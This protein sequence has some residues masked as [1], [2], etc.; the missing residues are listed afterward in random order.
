MPIITA[1]HMRRRAPAGHAPRAATTPAAAGTVAAR[2][3]E[4]ETR[5]CAARRSWVAVSPP[6]KLRE[7]GASAAGI[8]AG[9]RL[10]SAI[11][12]AARGGERETSHRL[13]R[14]GEFCPLKNAPGP[15]VARHGRAAT[16]RTAGA[17]MAEEARACMA[18]DFEREEK[19]RRTPS[20]GSRTSREETGRPN[21]NWCPAIVRPNHLLAARLLAAETTGAGLLWAGCLLLSFDFRRV[22]IGRLL[23][24]QQLVAGDGSGPCGPHAVGEGRTR[25]TD[26]VNSVVYGAGGRRF[27]DE[28]LCW[29]LCR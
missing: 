17:K 22:Q 1:H 21:P 14:D 26:A 11:G 2:R 19:A 25:R 16:V 27:E 3:A 9:G 24:A 4:R 23:L 10:R 12:G 20:L 28:G 5:P 29:P 18:A 13:G 15:A 7:I 8:A 6:T